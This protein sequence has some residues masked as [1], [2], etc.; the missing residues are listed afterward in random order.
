M[1]CI[2]FI[3][4]LFIGLFWSLYCL[5]YPNSKKKS[6]FVQTIEEFE[7]EQ[8]E[9]APLFCCSS[10]QETSMEEFPQE[11]RARSSSRFFHGLDDVL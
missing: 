7:K 8:I 11:G 2:D 3:G 4:F 6:N 10:P 1:K 5:C 9:E